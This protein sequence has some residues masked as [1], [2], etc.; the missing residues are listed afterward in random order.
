MGHHF[1]VIPLKHAHPVDSCRRAGIP[2]GRL[3]VKIAGQFLSAGSAEGSGNHRRK[4]GARQRIIGTEQAVFPV[5]Q[6]VF[7]GTGQA[8][9]GPVRRHVRKRSIPRIVGGHRR[10][11]TDG[12]GQNKQQG[13]QS[14][15]LHSVLTPFSPCALR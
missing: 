14:L 6:T 1:P 8:L 4:L 3:Y 11:H 15:R 10:R 12:H 7:H 9:G 2:I 13:R 5:Q